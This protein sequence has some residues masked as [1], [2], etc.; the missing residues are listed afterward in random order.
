VTLTTRLS[1]F[2]LAALAV[3]LLGFSITLYVLAHVYLHRQ[4]DERLNAVLGTLAACVEIGPDGMLEW[5]PAQH[6]LTFSQAAFGDQVLWQISDDKGIIVDRSKPG[7]ADDILAE[8]PE[9][10]H[11]NQR[12]TERLDKQGTPWQLGQRVVQPWQPASATAV[13]AGPDSRTTEKTYPALLISAAIPLDAVQAALQQLAGTLVGLSLGVW[14]LALFA[15]RLVCRRALGPLRQMAVYAGEI[16]ANNLGQRLPAISSQDELQDLNRAI[17]SLLDR[18]QDSFQ[19]QRRFTGD[20]SHQLRTP[21]AVILGQVEVALRRERS[22]EEYRRALTTVHYKSKHLRCIVEALLF[23]ART[24]NEALLPERQCIDLTS[25][26]SE[27]VRAWSDH[28]R[29]QDIRLE[30]APA[31]SCAVNVQPVLLGELLNILIDNACKYSPAGTPITIR[32]GRAAQLVSLQVEDQG[33]GI[34]DADIPHLFT[35]F[36]RSAAARRLGVDGFGLGLSIAKRIAEAFGG[37]LSVSSPA[38]RGCGVTLTLE[39]ADNGVGESY[40]FDRL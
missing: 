40:D 35:P 19:R 11:T 34:T 24:D 4:S 5:E 21:L 3:V 32:L 10:L 29:G 31:E 37:T 36:F 9:R 39:C 23:L 22:P 12:S 20:A 25:W 2:F 6:N 17:N 8:A 15:G 27:Q 16:N 38:G 26:L 28:E 1:W 7:G 14:V 13:G 18:L 33:C 30:G